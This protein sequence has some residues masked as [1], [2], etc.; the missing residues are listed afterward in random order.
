MMALLTACRRY[1][2]L[3]DGVFNPLVLDRLAAV[4]YDRSFELLTATPR[5]LP[6]AAT[7]PSFLDSIELDEAACS[8][9]ALPGLRLDLGGIGKGYAVD[10]V[11]AQLADAGGFLVEAGGDIYAAGFDQS[12]QPWRVEVADPRAPER[13][14]FNLRLSDQA[15]ATSWT[16]KRRWRAGAGWAHHLIDARS[17]RPAETGVIGATAVATS[18]AAADVFAKTALILG[19]EAGLSFLKRRC[20]AGLLVLVDG[21]QLTTP[22]WPGEPIET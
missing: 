7:V 16:V 20:V 6:P 19:P 1:A 5:S 12:G 13:S 2:T 10:G 3:T 15:V 21:H 9:T 4:G 11:A 8:V 14:L 18:A 17:G 22:D